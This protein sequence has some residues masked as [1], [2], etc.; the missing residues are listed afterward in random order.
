LKM[1]TYRYFTELEDE[2]TH[3]GKWTYG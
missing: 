1:K 3:I 2:Y